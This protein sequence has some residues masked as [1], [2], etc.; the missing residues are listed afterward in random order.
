MKK[1]KTLIALLLAVCLVAAL[2]AACA[3]TES[4]TPASP[5]TDKTDTTPSTSDNTGKPEKPDEPEVNE[6]VDEEPTDIVV[7]LYDM[8][9]RGEYGGPI[10][11]KANE[12]TKDAINVVA[13][14]RWI[15]PGDW[16]TSVEV[17]L[18]AGERFDVV[19][20]NPYSKINKVY[21]QGMVMDITDYIDEYA[22]GAYEA[23]KDYINCY[24]FGGRIYGFPTIRNYCRNEYILMRT[25]VLKDL[26]LVEKAENIKSWSEFNEILEEVNQKVTKVD[27]SMYPIGISQPAMSSDF[28]IDQDEFDKI[29]TVDNL[30]DSLEVL[31]ADRDGKVSFYQDSPTYRFALETCQNWWDKGYQWPDSEF[32]TQF[33]DEVMKGGVMFSM[34]CGSETGVKATKEANFGFEITVVHVATGCIKTSQPIF[35]GMCV[36]I[37]CE[38]PE[39]SLKWINMLYTSKELMNLLVWGI[40]GE[41]WHEEDGQ[42]V[43]DNEDGYMN[44][45]FVLGNNTLLVPIMGNGSDFY[46]VVLKTNE[47]ADKSRF[48]GFVID[49]GD[50]SLIMSQVSACKDEYSKSL[51]YGGYTPERLEEYKSKLE[52]AGVQDYIA[53]IQKQLDAWIAETGN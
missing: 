8:R 12:L 22:P 47:I 17:A 25:D 16:T 11:D 20:L 4:E 18:A 9:S 6:P 41:D 37:T 13:E 43:R 51:L 45:D 48:L 2:L 39:A 38:E 30:G 44:V 29:Y 49:T 19:N 35:S 5:S 34:V 3:K 21:P 28:V 26:G 53:E 32:T 24:T 7:I 36:P 40:E 14:Y 27:G 31:T 50:L 52:V 10:A 23:T 15:T 42:V 33:T 1:A 46:D